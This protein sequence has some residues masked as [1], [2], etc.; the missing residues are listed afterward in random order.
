MREKNVS[1]K[2]SPHVPFPLSPRDVWGL[3]FPLRPRHLKKYI[4][5]LKKKI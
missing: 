1:K 3:R 4:K 5:I 2:A